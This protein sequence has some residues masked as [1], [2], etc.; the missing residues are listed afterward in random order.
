MVKFPNTNLLLAVGG[1]IAA[2]FVIRELRSAGGD[3]QNALSGLKFPDINFPSF[4]EIN[5]PS[6]PDIFN[7][8]PED[9]A[10][11]LAGETIVTDDGTTITIPADNIVNPDGTVSGS[12]PTMNLSEA[13]RLE[14]LRQLELNRQ[15]SIAE[16][17]L[18]EIPASEDIS[19]AELNAARNADEFQRRLDQQA[20][21]TIQDFRDQQNIQ[22]DIEGNQFSGG[23]ISFIG[24]T[25]TETPIRFLSLGQIID[26]FN[27]SASRAAD[28]RAQ[29]LNDF[30]DFDFGTNTFN[31]QGIPELQNIGSV[32][33][34]Q[35]QG[36]TAEEIALRLTGGNISNF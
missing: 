24:G 10:S 33:D 26:R 22:T 16:Q 4:P 31:D 18:S 12:P 28:I 19:G 23:G 21:R 11:S 15:R 7:I 2:I 30:G 29:A 36:L 5:F 35:F 13:A 1:V 14:A 17:A 6:F 25:V 8:F 27:V 20:A 32:S 3:L 9:N 34:Q